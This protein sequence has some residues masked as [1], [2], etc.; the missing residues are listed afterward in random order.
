MDREE[1]RHCVDLFETP[2]KSRPIRDY[3]PRMID[4]FEPEHGIDAAV[5]SL[6][7]QISTFQKN[8]PSEYPCYKTEQTFSWRDPIRLN[9][10]LSDM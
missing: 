10:K 5:L 2:W 1:R 3:Y 9:L 6:R 7:W 8:G 4:Q